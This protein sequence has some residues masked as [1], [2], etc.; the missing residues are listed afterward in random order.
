MVRVVR[1]MYMAISKRMNRPQGEDKHNERC[2]LWYP[3][4]KKPCPRLTPKADFPFLPQEDTV[5]Y[6]IAADM[7]G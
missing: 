2:Q 4:L 5:C 1:A 6:L 3:S 7:P